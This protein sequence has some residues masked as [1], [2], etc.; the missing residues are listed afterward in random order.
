MS[1]A[2]ERVIA[3]Q[4]KTIDQLRNWQKNQIESWHRQNTLVDDLAASAFL[5]LNFP[6]QPGCQAELKKSI[7]AMGFCPVCEGR[8]CECE[9]QYDHTN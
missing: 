3:E 9:G 4:Q 1:E 7:V 5:A 2:L 6:D 8:P